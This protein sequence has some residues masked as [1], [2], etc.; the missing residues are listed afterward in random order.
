MLVASLQI[1]VR[2]K[3]VSV[4]LN[5]GVCPKAPL[6]CWLRPTEGFRCWELQRS[7]LYSPC[8]I[9]DTMYCFFFP[10]R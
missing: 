2:D 8:D 9:H 3:G 6:S 7:C 1:S 10:F 4:L 5:G